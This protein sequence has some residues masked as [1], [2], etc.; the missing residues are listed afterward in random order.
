[1]SLQTD[2]Y[3]PNDAK[4]AILNLLENADA[5]HIELTGLA[6]VN[7]GNRSIIE[8]IVGSNKFLLK[9]AA[10]QKATI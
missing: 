8:M 3:D 9:Q 5:L 2:Y 4:N 6:L 10:I 1:M 7:R